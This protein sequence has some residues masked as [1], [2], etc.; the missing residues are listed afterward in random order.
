VVSPALASRLS[1][2]GVP[3]GPGRQLVEWVRSGHPD[4]ARVV[5]CAGELLGEAITPAL[6]LIDP[7]AL[8]VTGDIVGESFLAG[9]DEALNR[10]RRAR[11][12]PIRPGRVGVQALAAGAHRLLVE[13]VYAPAAI[14][15]QLLAGT[16]GHP[17]LLE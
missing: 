1:A 10:A 15:A 11:R 5:R 16:V 6:R 7:D 9:L 2:L 8:V 17:A 4:A 13:R 12:V 3:T 14:D